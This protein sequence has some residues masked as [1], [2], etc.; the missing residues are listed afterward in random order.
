MSQENESKTKWTN[1]S[2]TLHPK[3][4]VGCMVGGFAVFDMGCSSRLLLPSHALIIA[5]MHRNSRR[6]PCHSGQLLAQSLS[7]TGNS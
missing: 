5:Q 1:S 2:Y 7:R 6:V 3:L 4:L